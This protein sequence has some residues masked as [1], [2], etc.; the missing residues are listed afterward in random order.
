MATVYSKVNPAGGDGYEADWHDPDT[1]DYAGAIP[2]DDDVA[3]INTS[4]TNQSVAIRSPVTADTVGVYGGQYGGL[5]IAGGLRSRYFVVVSAAV[6]PYYAVTGTGQLVVGGPTAATAI[7]SDVAAGLHFDG[8]IELV[9]GNPVT[10]LSDVRLHADT[11][12]RSML[13]RDSNL[14][15]RDDLPVERLRVLRSRIVESGFGC[16]IHTDDMVMVGGSLRSIAVIGSV[17]RLYGTEIETPE[18]MADQTTGVRH[19]PLRGAREAATLD[20]RAAMTGVA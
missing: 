13:I 4:T 12:I 17:A 16:P 20:R 7:R 5:R 14:R 2:A 19:A 15:I 3:I 18:F 1:W 11:Y 10:T 6:A 8:H 9:T